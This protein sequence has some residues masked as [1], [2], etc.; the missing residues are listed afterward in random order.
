MEEPGLRKIY[1]RIKTGDEDN[2]QAIAEERRKRIATS[3]RIGCGGHNTMQFF[4][5]EELED[6]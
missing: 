3:L 5:H 4:R 1:D 2:A 6:G